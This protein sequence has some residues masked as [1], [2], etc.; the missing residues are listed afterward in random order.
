VALG[1]R[2]QGCVAPIVLV[3]DEV[4]PPYQGPPPSKAFLNGGIHEFFAGQ[5]SV[6]FGAKPSVLAPLTCSSDS[7]AR[8][9]NNRLPVSAAA[10]SA[11]SKCMIEE[12][13]VSCGDSGMNESSCNTHDT[14]KGTS[15]EERER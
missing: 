15:D 2:Q 13:G 1:L 6:L 12:A 10:A 4:H 3:G 5:V 9:G 11:C 14:I 7:P 8:S